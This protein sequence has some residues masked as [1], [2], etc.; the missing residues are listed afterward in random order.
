MTLEERMAATAKFSEVLLQQITKNNE[1]MRQAFMKQFSNGI[2]Q[3]P[4]KIY[5]SFDPKDPN[6]KKW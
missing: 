6:N 2:I 3:N 1:A 4:E 5:L